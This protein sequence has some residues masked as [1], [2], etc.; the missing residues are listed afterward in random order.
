MS[1][2]KFVMHLY[3]ISE[4]EKPQERIEAM[5]KIERFREYR[6]SQKAEA[7]IFKYLHYWPHVIIREMTHL[8]GFENDSEWI[9]KMFTSKLSS[10]KVD[11]ALSFLYNS[12]LLKEKSNGEVA[13]EDPY[14]N[15]DGEVLRLSLLDFHRQMLALSSEVL[16]KEESDK[17]FIE[18]FTFAIEESKLAEVEKIM[19][20]A[21]DKV[22]KL[23]A[24][25]KQGERVIHAYVGFTPLTKKSNASDDASEKDKKEAA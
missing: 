2:E 16:V 15:C 10:Q 6:S 5:T 24:K 3:T 8:K 19:M 1:E 23:E 13:L 18:G 21:L 17:R 14:I 7:S 22:E 4:S 11:G 25:E 9:R 12:G 20:E